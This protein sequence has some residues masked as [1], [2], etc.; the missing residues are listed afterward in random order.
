MLFVFKTT[1]HWAPWLFAALAFSLLRLIRVLLFGPYLSKPVTRS[2]VAVWMLYAAT[3]GALTFRYTQRHPRGFERFGLVSFV[4]GIAA[5]AAYSATEPL[6]L[7]LALLGLAEWV[8][9]LLPKKTMR[10]A[11][12]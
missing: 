9:W 3:A 2:E 11:A 7:G 5:A 1:R 6:W 4:V 10:P 12:F 8:Q